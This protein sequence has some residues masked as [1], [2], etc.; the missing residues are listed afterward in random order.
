MTIR[1]RIAPTPSGYL[2]LGNAFNFLLTEQL[3]HKNNGSLRLRIDDLDTDRVRKEYIDDI[4]ESLQWLGITVDRGPA[5]P[6]EQA[7]EYSQHLRKSSYH[8]MLDLLVQTGRVF[9]CDCSRS[10][11]AK[12]AP[13]GHYPGTCRDK[14]IPLDSPNV[15]WRIRTEMEDAAH[16]MDGILGAQTI[17]LFSQN[18]DFVIRKKDGSAA[19]QLASFCD[20]VAFG[21]TLI[22]RGEDLLS[23][24]AAQLFLAQLLDVASFRNIDFYHHPLLEIE[25]KKLSK[26]EGSIS[27][28]AM[29]KAGISPVK[30]REDFAQWAMNFKH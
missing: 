24:T 4:F 18:P 22:V 11:I 28:R 10:Q 1:S 16:W 13:D 2:H 14:N 20:D 17:N 7:S 9:A 5:N 19:Y 29:R 3:T 6:A 25:G 8:E 23:S 26:T 21:I 27:L 30:I 12:H 15:A